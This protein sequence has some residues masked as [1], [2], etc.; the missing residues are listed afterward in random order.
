MTLLNTNE[1]KIQNKKLALQHSSTNH[2]LDTQVVVS[3][4]TSIGLFVLLPHATSA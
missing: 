4:L 2:V 1:N 3:H